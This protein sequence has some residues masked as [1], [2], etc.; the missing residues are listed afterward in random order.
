MHV[1]VIYSIGNHDGVADGVDI[2]VEC[3]CCVVVYVGSASGV[4]GYGCIGHVACITWHAYDVIY[5]VCIVEYCITISSV[6]DRVVVGVVHG[7]VV[8]GC[9]D[10]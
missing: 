6:L 1:V 4:A 5:S 2:G 8:V 3:E 7:C 9:D 10:Y